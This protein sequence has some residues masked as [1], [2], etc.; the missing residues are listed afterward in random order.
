MKIAEA[1]FKG[2]RRVFPGESEDID[3]KKSDRQNPSPVFQL[4]Y[5]DIGGH[6]QYPSAQREDIS[7]HDQGRGQVLKK[8]PIPR[9]VKEK[10]NAPKAV[11]KNYDGPES[12]AVGS[13]HNKMLS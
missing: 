5:P 2:L 1:V 4:P 8:V 11:N 10:K 7:K 9:S 6:Q 3:H 12:D 13:C